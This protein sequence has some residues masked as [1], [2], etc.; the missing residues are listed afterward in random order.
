MAVIRKKS[1][2]ILQIE[3]FALPLWRYQISASI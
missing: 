1:M 3:L 2:K